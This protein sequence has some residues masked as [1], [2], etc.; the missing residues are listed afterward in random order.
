[1]S[2]LYVP[3]VVRHPGSGRQ[4]QVPGHGLG[5]PCV[6]A[7]VMFITGMVKL[8][9]STAIRHTLASSCVFVQYLGARGAWI[10]FNR[11]FVIFYD[12]P[13]GLVY[14]GVIEIK[15]FG[16]FFFWVYDQIVN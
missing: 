13:Q 7:D 8:A 9:R 5:I 15:G 14:P 16:F 4:T 3:A 1:M 11:C 2:C 10:F 6:L 12:L